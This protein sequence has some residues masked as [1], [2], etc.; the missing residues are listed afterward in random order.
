MGAYLHIG[1]VAKATTKLP[2]GISKAKFLEQ[3]KDHYPESTYDCVE[4][5]GKIAFALKSEVL[6]AE[7]L[8]F[9]RQ[10]YKDFHGDAEDRELKTA[11]KFI[12]ENADKPDWLEKTEEADLYE[13]S[14][15]DYGFSDDFKIEEKKVRLSTMLVSLGS[16][17]KFLMEECG[18]TLHF[19]ETCAHRAYA[20]FKI[21]TSFRVFIL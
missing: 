1:F 6:Q 15:I 5:E 7:L 3:I 13:F 4:S 9:V 21:G 11:L 17:G 20:G 8:P 18:K 19:M 10:V 14:L 16:E 2:D 12:E